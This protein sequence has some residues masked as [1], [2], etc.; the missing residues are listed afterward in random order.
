MSQI[1]KYLNW[2]NCRKD[3]KYSKIHC[4]CNFQLQLFFGSQ[5]LRLF[6]FWIQMCFDVVVI[7][8]V[9]Q[10]N[11]GESRQ[12]QNLI[13][14]PNFSLSFQYQKSI[15]CKNQVQNLY[16]QSQ[17][18]KYPNLLVN[19]AENAGGLT[20]LITSNNGFPCYS[21]VMQSTN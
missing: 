19:V 11:C 1:P 10:S 13:C 9:C 21:F 4:Q 15:H 7:C 17:I 14:S 6:L 12:H 5:R 18:A 8:F 2:S 3:P 16:C 20:S